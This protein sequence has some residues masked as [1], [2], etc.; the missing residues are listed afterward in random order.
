MSNELE[1]LK[2]KAARLYKEAQNFDQFS[3]G[4]QLSE[5]FN[6]SIGLAREEFNKIW[7]RVREL[8]PSAPKNPFE[9]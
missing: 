2:R 8:D 3:C 1:T 6:P 4:R 9:N 7:L 5:Y